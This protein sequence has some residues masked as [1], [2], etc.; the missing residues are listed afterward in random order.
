[1]EYILFKVQ[2]MNH[3]NKPVINIH[4]VIVF[5]PYHAPGFKAMARAMVRGF[6]ERCYGEM[7]FGYTHHLCTTNNA[8]GE[9]FHETIGYFPMKHK[10]N[11]VALKA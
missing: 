7:S 9:L 8:P 10:H 2:Y 1:M 6:I 3:Q 4:E 11:T 5:L